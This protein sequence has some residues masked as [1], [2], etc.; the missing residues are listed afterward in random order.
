MDTPF[1]RVIWIVLDSVGIGALPD[2]ADY[3]DVGRDTL[4]HIAR[5]RPLRLPNLI[6]LGLANVKPLAHLTPPAR[7]AGAFGKGITVSPGKD[8]TTGHWEMAGI[9]LDQAFPVYKNGFP[10][11]LMEKF[12]RAIGRKTIGNKPA[13]GTEIIKELGEEHQRTGFPIVYTSGDSVFQIAAHEDTIPIAE[14]YK[15][16]EIARKLLD[17]PHRVG[18]VI[19]RPFT[20]APGNY[21]RTERRHDYAVEPP[22]SMLLDVLADAKIPVF[23]VGKIHDIYNGRGVADYVTTR[24]NA[25]GMAKLTAALAQQPRGLIFANLVDFDMLYGHRKDV[26]GFARSLEE[27]D[28]LLGP[29]LAALSDSD[30]LMITADHGCDPDPVNP[31]TDHSREYVPILCY[32]PRMDS[33]NAG[34]SSVNWTVEKVGSSL[35]CPERSRRATR[36]SLAL[37]LPAAAGDVEGSLPLNLGVRSTL[38]D[39]GQTVAENFSAAPLLHGSSFLSL[40]S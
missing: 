18:R 12:E 34:N 32:S 23:G 2:A 13:S 26:E 9:W 5:S 19:A 21:R 3:G 24:N 37:S 28:A 8:T 15:M 39:M 33:A 35:A 1:L 36:H 27:F 7:P 22:R 14:L 30:L 11:D 4:G 17:G 25:D 40:L 31:T 20:G 10:R 6:R 16:C 29:F 38:A